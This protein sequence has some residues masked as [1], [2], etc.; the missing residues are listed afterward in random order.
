[1][2]FK[3]IESIIEQSESYIYG[4]KDRVQIALC[5]LLAQGHLLIEDV[6]GVGKTTLVKFLAKVMGLD[7]SRIQF[8]NDL[9][10]FDIIGSSFFNKDKNE[11]IFRKGPIFGEV[12][13]ADELNRAPA[14]TQSALLQVMEERQI[15]VEDNHF[16]LDFPFIVIATQNPQTQIGTFELPESQLDRFMMRINM[17][18]PSRESNRELLMAKDSNEKISELRPILDKDVFKN[19]INTVL[20]VKTS[21]DIISY[22][23][24]ILE[25]SR[26]K[27]EYR[28]LS[29]RAG[30]DI[31][32]ASKSWA[33]I[34]ERDYVLP[35]D[36]QEIFPYIASHRLL[37]QDDSFEQTQM[38][39]Q[40]FIKTIPVS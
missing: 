18:Y 19:L 2:S 30:I 12:I 32:A 4:K 14:K 9:L 11:F 29:N 15:S 17:G 39:C 6:P 1:M 36:I 7:F 20:E 21:N 34:N 33:F 35:S 3:L 28:P 22:V 8:T 23:L 40:A 27:S 13:L 25:A 37:A 31:I 5:C 26:T 16:K 38:K 24:D 10:P